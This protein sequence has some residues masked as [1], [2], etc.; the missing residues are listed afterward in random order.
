MTV[1]VAALV[2]RRARRGRDQGPEPRRRH[3]RVEAG[4]ETVM[5]DVAVPEAAAHP[6]VIDRAERDADDWP[7][8]AGDPRAGGGAVTDAATEVADGRPRATDRCCPPPAWSRTSPSAGACSPARCGRRVGGGRRQPRGRHG[9]DPGPGGRVGLRQVD[10][11]AN[12]AQPDHAHR[13]GG[14]VRR[15]GHQRLSKGKRPGRDAPALPDRLPGP[16]RL[17]QPPHDRGGHAGRTAQGPLRPRPRPA[18]D[19][20]VA[21]LLRTVG[22]AP[23]HTQPL[24]ARVLGRAAPAGRHR[25]GAGPRARADRARRAGVR[26]RRVHPGRRGQ[27]A[28]AAAGRAGARLRVHR[29]RPVG[30]PPHLDAGGGHVPGQDRRDRRAGARSTSIRRIPTPRRCCRRSRCPIRA[31]EGPRERIIL[32]GDVPSPANPPSG[33][34]FRTRCWRKRALDEA[35]VDTSVC[36]EQ[37]PLLE[38]RPS[39]GVEHPVACHFAERQTVV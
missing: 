31:R 13:R 32:T 17:A 10:H 21:D 19:E 11:R 27:P 5:T 38:I 37:E 7:A 36:V 35:G 26:A 2:G 25:P 9:G 4:D 3:V 14:V 16:V 39:S 6:G 23:E 33:C 28:A 20:R 12:A 30:G 34:R 15:P 8:Q 29:P 18:I 24:P 22:L 1:R